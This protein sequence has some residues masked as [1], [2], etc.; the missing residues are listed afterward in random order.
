MVFHLQS[1]HRGACRVPCWGHREA[2]NIG[3]YLCHHSEKEEFLKHNHSNDNTK[4]KLEL[5]DRIK[6]A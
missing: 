4:M 6:R 2:A 1:H 3:G 5:Q